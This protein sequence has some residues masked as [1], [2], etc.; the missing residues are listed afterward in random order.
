MFSHARS[1]TSIGLK[2]TWKGNFLLL[3]VAML[4]SAGIS[5]CLH[6]KMTA[7]TRD[8]ARKIAA[9][10]GKLP[11]LPRKPDAGSQR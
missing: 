4:V 5:L 8:G 11:E 2:P 3:L 7:L 9:N 10:V 6:Y 1:P